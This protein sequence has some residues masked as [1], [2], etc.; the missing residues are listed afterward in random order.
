MFGLDSS[1]LPY[2]V[3]YD[4]AIRFYKSCEKY[5]QKDTIWRGVTSKR[6][7]SKR[8]RLI[9]DTLICQYHNTDVVTLS[10]TSVRVEVYSSRST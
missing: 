3:N 9:D 10:P 6:D 2:C 1:R 5:T 4:A 8:M 7:S